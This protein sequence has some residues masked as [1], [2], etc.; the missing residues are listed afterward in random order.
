MPF[1]RAY[2]VCAS[3]NSLSNVLSKWVS[4]VY[5]HDHPRSPICQLCKNRVLFEKRLVYYKYIC[6]SLFAL[7]W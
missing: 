7:T 6:S 3:L 5:K 4:I 1:K 2:K